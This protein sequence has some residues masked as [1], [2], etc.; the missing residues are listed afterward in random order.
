MHG[1]DSRVTKQ[2]WSIIYAHC[3]AKCNHGHP[4]VILVTRFTVAISCADACQEFM[5]GT[6]AIAQ[7]QCVD[8][9]PCDNCMCSLHQGRL[10]IRITPKTTESFLT[11]HHKYSPTM[12][13]AHSTLRAIVNS[14]SVSC[15]VSC[16]HLLNLL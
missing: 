3:V 11:H 15:I 4:N 10:N 8:S 2:L 5:G 7:M 12:V 14:T 9:N 6:S 16:R 13:I 1:D